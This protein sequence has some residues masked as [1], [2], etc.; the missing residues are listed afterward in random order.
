MYKHICWVI[1]L[2]FVSCSGNK[3]NANKM[4]NQAQVFYEQGALSTAKTYIDSM[5]VTYPKEFSAIKKGLQLMRYIELK[6]NE[7][8]LAYTDSMLIVKQ[9]EA[10]ELKKNFDFVKDSAYDEIGNY[11]YKRL[12]IEK[13]IQRCYIRVGVNEYGEIYL[14]SVYYGAKNIN[15]TGIKAEAN[16]GLSAQTEA[17]PYDGG[18]NYRFTDDGAQTE[19]VTYLKGKDNGVLNFISLYADQRIKITY[20]GEKPYIMVLDNLS[21]EAIT[22]SL[23][24]STVLSDV[25]R[26]GQENKIAIGKI[27][28]LKNKI[29]SK[30]SQISDK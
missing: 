29:N 11:I 5:R 24:L 8:N 3:E 28:F 26:L 9:A 15:H 6:E 13:N 10:E 25:T 18:R 14:S 27:E 4:L 2:I 12:G 7:R 23:E 19:V 17:I 1:A 22:K 16:D 30:E 20:T 21:K